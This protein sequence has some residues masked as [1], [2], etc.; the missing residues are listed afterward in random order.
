[1]RRVAF[2]ATRSSRAGRPL[3]EIVPAAELPPFMRRESPNPL[4]V[5]LD[6]KAKKPL[7]G[8]QATAV[9]AKAPPPEIEEPPA[10]NA[11][12]LQLSM[13]GLGLVS[14]T[15]AFVGWRKRQRLLAPPPKEERI[16]IQI[17]DL[18]TD[19]PPDEDAGPAVSEES[20]DVSREED[21]PEAELEADGEEEAPEVEEVPDLGETGLGEPDELVDEEELLAGSAAL[22]DFEDEGDNVGRDVAKEMAAA[23]AGMA[24]E[25]EA[26][27]DAGE[28]SGDSESGGGDEEWAES[29]LQDITKAVAEDD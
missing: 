7:P 17:Q 19:N 12:W 8:A 24:E 28:A 1:M 9:V 21:A 23:V 4:A 14:L 5:G 18:E 10:L 15:G 13:M 16:K 26:E 6:P 20:P 2:L 3:S 22:K 29:M 11:G 25:E 27:E